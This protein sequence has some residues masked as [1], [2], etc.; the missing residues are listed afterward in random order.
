VRKA[1][2]ALHDRK[3]PGAPLLVHKMLEA[4]YRHH[5][6]LAEAARRHSGL[7]PALVR[8]P[9]AS[10]SAHAGLSRPPLLP[11][12]PVLMPG[13]GESTQLD[14]AVDELML[15]ESSMGPPLAVP[16]ELAP[17]SGDEPSPELEPEEPGAAPDPRES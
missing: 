2:H 4:R 3:V 10:P 11:P 13:P 8:P 6:H 15:T 1:T 12:P 5:A 14:E 7:P 17:T 16:D 9:G